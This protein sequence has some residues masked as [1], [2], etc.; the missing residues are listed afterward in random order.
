MKGSQI[1]ADIK[2]YLDYSKWNDEKQKAETWKDSV[3]RVMDMHRQNPKLAKAFQNPRFVELFDLTNT[4]Y[5][6]QWLLGSNR[7]LQFGGQPMMK[8]QMRMYNCFHQDTPFITKE[9]VRSFLDFNDGDEIVVLTHEGNWKPAIVKNYGKAWLNEITIQRGNASYKIKATANHRWILKSGQVINELKEKQKLMSAKDIF[10]KFLYEDS[11]PLERLYWAYGYIFGDGTRVKNKEGNYS[12]SMVRLCNQDRDFK[13]RFEELGFETSQ[14]LSCKGDFIAYTGTYLKTPPNPKTDS[15][16]L[17]RAFVAGYLDADGIKNGNRLYNENGNNPFNGIQSSEQDHQQF[18][19]ECFPVAGI[20]IVSEKEMKGNTNLGERDAILFRTIS[21]LD[22]EN[23]YATAFSVKEINEKIEK[24]DVWC[25]EVEDDKSFVLPFGLVTGNC[26]ASYC[27]RV[28][29]FQES[30]YLLLCGCGTGF[31]VQQHHVAKLPN[32]QKR[33]KGTQTFVISDSIEGWSDAVGVLMSSYVTEGATF[34][35]YQGYDIKFDFSLIRPK[36]S[37]ITGGF[38]APGSDGLRESLLKIEG[39]IERTLNEGVNSIRPIIAYDIVMHAAD[40]VLSGGVRRSATICLF[41]PEDEEMLRAKIPENY[42]PQAGINRQRARSNNSVVLVRN[43]MTYEKFTSVFEFIKHYGE[44][45]FYL[46]D[47]KDQ[48]ANPC[49]EIGMWGY[50]D[51]ARTQSGWQGCNL[52]TGN[53]RECDTREKFLKICIGLAVLATIQATYTDFQYVTSI[54]KEIFEREAL[55]GCSFSGWMANPEIMLDEELQREGAQ[56]ILAI[57]DEVSRIL[58]INPAARAT[59]AKPEGNSSVL[60]QCPSGV[61]GDHSEWYFR[62]MQVN[63]ESE[64]AK[65]MMEHMPHMVEESIWSRDKTDIVVYIPVEAR[66]GSKFKS[67]LV[68]IE[69][70]KVVKSIQQNWVEYGT[71]K[72]RCV[73]SFIRHNVSNTVEVEDWEPVIDYLFENRQYFSGVSFLAKSGDKDYKQAPFTSILNP[74]QL[75]DKYSTAALF[76]SG[77]IVDGLDAFDNDLWDAC[78]AVI[79]KEYKLQGTRKDKLIQKEWIRRAKQFS[80]RYFKHNHQEMILCVK[81]IYLYH[82]WVEVNREMKPVNFEELNLKPQ[83]TDVDTIGAASCY[84]GA[85]EIPQRN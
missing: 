58:D 48:L 7:A 39:L 33:I 1:A 32:I 36:G 80:K 71:R 62:I 19:R 2:Y 66:P 38:K 16:E 40:A 57:N 37:M 61:H 5:E 72:E 14:P 49:V 67:E 77:L 55:I 22:R 45:G 65:Y 8:H 70:L 46:V 25:L 44:P 12:Y 4:L 11:N 17:I 75:L 18:I 74:Q 82:K 53:G 68:G 64:I 27:D 73:E 51:K 83:Y 24:T 84:N 35:E 79:N 78:E 47:D 34:P 63:K 59:C 13:S 3:G 81:D 85:C 10:K 69:Q 23:K 76:A 43:E 52:V 20:Y 21:Q 31:S 41:S 56:L 50:L 6:N 26:L 42:N 29:F 15:P 60:F 9:G 30:L 54:T 28:A